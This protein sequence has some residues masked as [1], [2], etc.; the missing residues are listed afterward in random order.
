MPTEKLVCVPFSNLLA[1][2]VGKLL[3]MVGLLILFRMKKDLLFFAQPGKTIIM[4]KMGLLLVTLV[5]SIL[6]Q[7]C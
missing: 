7:L 3:L 6:L 2:R 1:I 5:L 4:K